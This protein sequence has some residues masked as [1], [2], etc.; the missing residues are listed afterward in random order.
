MVSEQTL[1]TAPIDKEINVI[2]VLKQVQHI[3]VTIENDEVVSKEPNIS[4]AII[5]YAS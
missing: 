2:P 5:K 3:T 4:P 1:D